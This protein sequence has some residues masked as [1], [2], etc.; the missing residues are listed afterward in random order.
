LFLCCY[1]QQLLKLTF[2]FKNELWTN[3]REF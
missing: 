1:E 2:L 3:K